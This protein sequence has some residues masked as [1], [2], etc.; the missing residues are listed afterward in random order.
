MRVMDG[1]GREAQG[2]QDGAQKHPRERRRCEG[3]H[4]SAART[5]MAPP[6]SPGK[7]GAFPSSPDEK[8]SRGLKVGRS[9]LFSLPEPF[10]KSPEP[11]EA[12]LFSRTR[13]RSPGRDRSQLAAGKCAR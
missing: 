4:R 1:E 12:R 2:R 6:R 13:I 3:G 5:R 8:R 10:L 9:T 7:T 11:A